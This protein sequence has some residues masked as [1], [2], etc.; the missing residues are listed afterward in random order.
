MSRS[1]L[2]LIPDVWFIIIQMLAHPY[3]VATLLQLRLTA[4]WLY[5]A[6]WDVVD[7]SIPE[8]I[9]A[10]D[11]NGWEAAKHGYLNRN[12]NGIIQ[13]VNLEFPGLDNFRHVEFLGKQNHTSSILQC[14]LTR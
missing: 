8:E 13:W 11:A 4:Y 7:F 5:C 9:L 10:S 2:P 6:V 3:D 12:S 14:M 1:I